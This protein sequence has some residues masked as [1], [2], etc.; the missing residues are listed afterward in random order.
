MLCAVNQAAYLLRRQI[1]QQS[2]EFV[3]KGGFTEGLYATRV[4]ARAAGR[5][6]GSAQPDALACPQCGKPM[7]TRTAAKRAQ[8]GQSFWGCSG[9]PDCKGTRKMSDKS[10]KSDS[11]VHTGGNHS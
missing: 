9:Y 3:E 6:K 4:S 11:G 5:A 2:R 8:A 10:D 7:R 1:E